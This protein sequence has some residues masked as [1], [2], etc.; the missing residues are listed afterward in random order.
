MQILMVEFE[1]QKELRRAN[2]LP[3]SEYDLLSRTSFFKEHFRT[4]NT[5][6]S[7]ALML[8]MVDMD[9]DNL[10]PA[11]ATNSVTYYLD[12]MGGA[13]SNSDKVGD[14]RTAENLQ[15]LGGLVRYI[16]SHPINLRLGFEPDVVTPI[17]ENVTF[18]SFRR[19][20]E[21]TVRTNLDS[22]MYRA[23][24]SIKVN[25]T[26]D[27]ISGNPLLESFTD[28]TLKDTELGYQYL[29]NKN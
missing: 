24:I 1:N 12:F 6:T 13:A 11:S 26:T 22:M 19:M 23:I 8:S 9:F 10:H 2:G 3:N 5:V 29:Y 15:R 14:Q 16:I 18:K 27:L 28:I 21:V 25:E 4:F 17:V 7:Y 20:E